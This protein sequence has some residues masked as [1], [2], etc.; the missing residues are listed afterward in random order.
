[1]TLRASRL[2]AGPGCDSAQPRAL[3]DGPSG[4]RSQV[5]KHEL[6]RLILWRKTRLNPEAIASAVPASEGSSLSLP[7]PRPRLLCPRQQIPS[8]QETHGPWEL[9]ALPRLRRRGGWL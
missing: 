3:R 4:S 9:M 8:G 1:M 2:S 5:P 7:L 6:A